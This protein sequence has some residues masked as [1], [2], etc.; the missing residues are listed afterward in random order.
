[1]R[2]LIGA[3]TSALS[4]ISGMM[5]A[6]EG[7]QNDVTPLLLPGLSNHLHAISTNNPEAQK[8]FDQG[9]MLVFG[10]TEP[11]RCARFAA[12][13]NWTLRYVCRIGVCP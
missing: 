12:L 8:Y 9:L 3:I 5:C 1:M 10:F 7:G 4:A 13:R 6:Q 11:R 2:N